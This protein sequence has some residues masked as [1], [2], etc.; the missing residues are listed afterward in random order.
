VYERYEG[1]EF[2]N[3]ENPSKKKNF[4]EGHWE[5]NEDYAFGASEEKNILDYLFY[6]GGIDATTKLGNINNLQRFFMNSI[7]PTLN[8]NSPV[9]NQV[10]KGF[11]SAGFLQDPN[12]FPQQ[13]WSGP[14]QY[15]NGMPGGR[16]IV[17]VRA[18]DRNGSAAGMYY[19][20]EVPVYLPW[21]ATRN[22]CP[23]LSNLD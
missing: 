8:N 6:L 18:T 19:E 7:A 13:P 5:I 15:G 17:T 12:N 11:L 9:A 21:W 23:L 3:D 1:N 4:G 10:A 2:G 22:N 14:H 20:F 16:Y